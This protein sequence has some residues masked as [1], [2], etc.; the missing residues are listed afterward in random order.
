MPSLI[1]LKNKLSCVSFLILGLLISFFGAHAIPLKTSVLKHNMIEYKISDES[2]PQKEFFF[3][4][5][6]KGNDIFYI[7]LKKSISESLK[8]T[9]SLSKE[10]AEGR[11]KV[12]EESNQ[13]KTSRDC[14]NTRDEDRL[15]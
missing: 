5:I 2:Y 10:E 13:M 4:S 6:H 1:F 12:L 3:V 15:F 7:I 14:G 8:K 11:R 9:K